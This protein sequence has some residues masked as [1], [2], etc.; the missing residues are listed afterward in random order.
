MATVIYRALLYCDYKFGVEGSELIY[1]DKNDISDFA[2]IAITMLSANGLVKGDGE[3]F[4][5]GENLTRA[6]A[7][8]AIARLIQ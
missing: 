7:A 6:E 3:L 5:P 4:Y 8:V 1:T 2:R